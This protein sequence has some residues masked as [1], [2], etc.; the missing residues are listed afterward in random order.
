VLYHP[1]NDRFY[2]TTDA[3]VNRVS[4]PIAA[5]IDGLMVY[6]APHGKRCPGRKKFVRSVKQTILALISAEPT[7]AELRTSYPR[8]LQQ[9]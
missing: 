6:I 5:L 2:D 1:T 7:E 8:R 3:L 9:V 4:A